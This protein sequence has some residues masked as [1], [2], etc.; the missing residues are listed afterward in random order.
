MNAVIRVRQGK[1]RLALANISGAMMI[2]AT[3]PI[4]LGPFHLL[5][6]WVDHVSAGPIFRA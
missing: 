6:T 5:S 1:C 4:A 2:Q 3:I